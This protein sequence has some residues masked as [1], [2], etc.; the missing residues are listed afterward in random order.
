MFVIETK[1][2]VLYIMVCLCSFC[3]LCSMSPVSLD[4]PFLL[5]LQRILCC[6][7]LFIFVFV[8]FCILC[9]MLSVTLDCPLWL[10]LQGLLCCI[11]LCLYEFCILC[12]MLPL[13]LGRPL[14]F[15]PSGVTLLYC[16]L[17]VFVL[18]HMLHS[19]LPL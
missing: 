7:V 18:Y 12:S 13:S 15:S 5:S 11:V 6:I 10:P 4:F 16:V 2:L 3:I 9:S 17:L 14:L 19:W 1:L 8:A